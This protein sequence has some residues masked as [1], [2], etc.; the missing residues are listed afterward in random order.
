MDERLDNLIQRDIDGDYLSDAERQELIRALDQEPSALEAH[1]QLGQVAGIL[2]QVPELE[3]PAGTRAAILNRFARPDS[4]AST[5][6]ASP[7][8][9]HNGWRIAYLMAAG[10]VLGLAVGLWAGQRLGTVP[11]QDT[12]GLF[13]T[14]GGA[15]KMPGLRVTGEGVTGSIDLSRTADGWVVAMGLALTVP[16]EMELAFDSQALDLQGMVQPDGHLDVAAEPG[17]VGWSLSPGENEPVLR[18]VTRGE[19]ESSIQVTIS[20]GGQVLY[21][22][23]LRVPAAGT[24]SI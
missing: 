2:E 6:T 14:M 24:E 16:A 13:G 9:A 18:F 3:P 21:R 10:I 15:A 23:L 11:Q 17:R 8:A 19:A 1:E 7:P 5:R 22:D 20:S 4:V 12:S